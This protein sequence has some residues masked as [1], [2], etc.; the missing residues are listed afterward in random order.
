MEKLRIFLSY[1]TLAL[2]PLLLAGISIMI[3][4]TDLNPRQA[5]FGL[6]IPGLVICVLLVIVAFCVDNEPL[7]RHDLNRIKKGEM[8]A[9]ESDRLR[10]LVNNQPLSKSVSPPRRSRERYWGDL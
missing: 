5:V 6:V 8:V 9:M 1:L 10:Y 2:I 3:G 4:F 7:A